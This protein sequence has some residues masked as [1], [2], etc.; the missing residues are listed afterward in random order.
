[1]SEE[2]KDAVQEPQV[3]E[4]EQKL[5]TEYEGKFEVWKAKE[6]ATLREED[7]KKIQDEV[8]KLFDKWQRDQKP[9]SLEEIKTLLEQEYAEVTIKIPVYNDEDEKEE[10]LFVIREL[11]Q[12][13][14]QKFYKQFKD[15]VKQ[16]GPELAA[17]TQRNID[18]SFE[19]QLSAFLETFDGAFDVLADA[20]LLILN[21]KGK[22]THVD[23][24]WVQENIS[25]NR[26]YSIILAQ[27]EVNRLRD[28]FSRVFQS[29]QKASTMMMPLNFQ[30][31]QALAR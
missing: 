24:K 26:M 9:P 7:D 31:L 18:Q 1:M 5:R 28:F 6:L 12:S 11:P 29:G 17:F 2:V 8:K 15:R 25:S 27:V 10:Q 13:I 4:L 3:S 23:V 30:Q 14:E 22:K 19:K 21:P 16:K 20:V